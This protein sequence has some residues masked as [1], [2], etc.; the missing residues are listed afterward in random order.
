MG[1]KRNVAS[2]HHDISTQEILFAALFVI[3]T[4]ICAGII[5]VSWLAID[6]S[7]TGKSRK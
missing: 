2:K 3:L 6:G 4:V 5:A 1:S 7:E